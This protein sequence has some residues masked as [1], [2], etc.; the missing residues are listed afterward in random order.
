MVTKTGHKC[1]LDSCRALGNAGFDAVC[2]V[3][4]MQ[5]FGKAVAPGSRVCLEPVQSDG[6]QERDLRGGTAAAPL[7]IGLGAAAELAE[8]V[9]EYDHKCIHFLSKHLFDCR[10]KALAQA[11]RNG[12]PEQTYSDCLNLSFAYVESE[13][14]KDVLMVCHQFYHTM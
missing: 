13:S 6:G 2:C 3:I 4:N 14:L 8:Q 5:K 7:G 11:K 9:M 10:M 1:V 12:H